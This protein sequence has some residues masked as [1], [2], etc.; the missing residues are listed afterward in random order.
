M[1]AVFF[2]SLLAAALLC[3]A[4]WAGTEKLIVTL[5]APESQSDPRQ[6]YNFKLIKLALDATA[7]GDDYEIRVSPPMNTA[8]ALVETSKNSLPNL[9]VMTTFTNDFLDKGI[10]Y[11]HVPIDFGVT[12]YRICFVSPLARKAF[13]Q[14]NT[15]DD[16][17]AFNIGQGVGWADVTILRYN[18][19]KVTEVASYE[20]LFNMVAA[21][22]ID[23]FCRGINELEPEFKKHQ[24]IRNLDYDTH[25]AVA[26]A[27]PRFFFSNKSNSEALRR[28]EA[29][30]QIAYKNG[31]MKKLWLDEFREALVFANL[32]KRKILYLSTP[33]IDRIDFD[34]KQYYLN[35]KEVY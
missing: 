20:S 5:T 25:I 2:R 12:G 35:P 11:V 27:L 14:V 1:F 13:S 16:L 32:S 17:K 6:A 31:T 19:L 29:G 15:L 33:N 18:G 7:T 9:L 4:C 30:M 8:R 28:I 10:D 23:L 26:Y 24:K 3:N 21:S 34:Y 22:R